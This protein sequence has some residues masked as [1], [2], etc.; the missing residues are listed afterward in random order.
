MASLTH[1][2]GNVGIGT[3]RL[4]FSGLTLCE[5]GCVTSGGFSHIT[6]LS[7]TS[8][9]LPEIQSGVWAVG[10]NGSVPNVITLT[11]WLNTTCSGDPSGTTIYDQVSI[12]VTWFGVTLSCSVA[13]P[14]L[15]WQDIFSGTTLATSL[16]S[17]KTIINTLSCGA[18]IL[19]HGG[20]VIISRRS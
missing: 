11:N 13:A 17:P 4:I 1:G 19:A 18:G 3:L 2:I 9:T 8:I 16:T 14:D 15:G 7:L 12:T 6:A 20:Q 10:G 5:S